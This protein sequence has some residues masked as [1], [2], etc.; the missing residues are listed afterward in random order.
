MD[1]P[2][3][4]SDLTREL[5]QLDREPRPTSDQ[6]AKT[7]VKYDD[8]RIVLIALRA[9]ARMPGHHAEGRISV[10]T[11]RGHIRVHKGTRRQLFLRQLRIARITVDELVR[12]LDAGESVSIIDLRCCCGSRG[13]RASGPWRA[14]FRPG[15]RRLPVEP[16]ATHAEAA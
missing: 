6:N 15:A 7:L 14:G 11:L 9:N 2:F 3:L 12:K 4:E 1:S 10:Q 16:I 8:F 5:E 13:S